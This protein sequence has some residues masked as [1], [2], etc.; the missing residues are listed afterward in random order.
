M[1]PL[2]GSLQNELSWWL[3]EEHRLWE[4]EQVEPLVAMRRA[5]AQEKILELKKVLNITA[6]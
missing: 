3:R 2:H 5:M 6:W 1:E 4:A